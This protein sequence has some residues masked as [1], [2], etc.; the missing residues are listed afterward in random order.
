MNRLI[1]FITALIVFT[2]C[3]SL[4]PNPNTTST[5]TLRI[6]TYNIHHANPPS[7]PEGEIDLTAICKVLKDANPDLIALQEVDSNTIRSGNIDQAKEIAEQLDMHYYFAK[8]IDFQG[9]SYG[10]AILSRYPIITAQTIPLPDDAV[11]ENEDRIVASTTISLPNNKTIRFASTHLDASSVE[12]R[13]LQVA[14]IKELGQG[15]QALPFIIAGDFNAS[16]KS[17]P[18]RRLQEQFDLG[19][20]HC[21]FTSPAQGPIRTI[22]FIAI[23]KAHPCRV[24]SYQVIHETYASDHLPILASV[25]IP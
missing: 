10:Q 5:S 24:L 16:K 8:A 9:G 4:K 13:L 19:C 3:A 18:I 22:D 1:S 23:N 6:L 21:E 12:N 25:E 2:S 20:S 11:P 7:K 15:E 17:K 14:R